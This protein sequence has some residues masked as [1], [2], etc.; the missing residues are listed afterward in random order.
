[1]G[2]NTAFCSIEP[3]GLV[4]IIKQPSLFSYGL[5]QQNTAQANPKAMENLTPKELEDQKNTIT[6]NIQSAN[7]FTYN[8]KN[9]IKNYIAQGLYR[10]PDKSKAKFL[11]ESRKV[12]NTFYFEFKNVAEV[13]NF[14]TKLT[15][16]T[17]TTTQNGQFTITTVLDPF[18]AFEILQNG[19]NNEADKQKI[20][21]TKQLLRFLIQNMKENKHNIENIY[22]QLQ[23]GQWHNQLQR[24]PSKKK[25]ANGM[26]QQP[27]QQHSRAHNTKINS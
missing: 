24:R 25:K 10:T 8:Q 17:K 15:E 12:L 6:T 2:S 22:R 11:K 19:I 26:N 4:T 14:V 20:S 13:Q 1:M 23:W 7:C 5:A 18:N 3:K 9:S 16:K 27:S 21:N